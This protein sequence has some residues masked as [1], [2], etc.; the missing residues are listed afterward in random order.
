MTGTAIFATV[1]LSDFVPFLGPVLP[2]LSENT[3]GFFYFEFCWAAAAGALVVLIAGRRGAW[4]L[5]V[6][7]ALAGAIVMELVYEAF[8]EPPSWGGLDLGSALG[9]AFF[10][11]L[12]PYGPSALLGAL[13]SK[14]VLAS[15]GLLR[16]LLRRRQGFG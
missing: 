4:W 15:A 6:T 14:L 10:L 12:F 11:F 2:D 13:V 16:G 8:L 9:D 5:A 1:P 7:G 3:M